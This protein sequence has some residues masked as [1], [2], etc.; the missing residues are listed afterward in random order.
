VAAEGF[1]P[2]GYRWAPDGTLLAVARVDNGPVN[3]WY[4]ADPAH[5]ERPPRELR[6][7]T[8]GTPNALVSLWILGLD[9]SR[10][11]VRWDRA[12]YE[13]LIAVHW[14]AA[15]L[16][17]TV[18][19]R[20]QSILRVFAADP[21]TG[22]TRLLR[23]ERD[24]AWVTVVP[25]VPVLTA[26]GALVTTMDLDGARRLAVDGTPVTPDGLQVRE[27]LAVDGETV[28]FAASAEP[29]EEHVWAYTGGALER[30]TAEPGWHHGWRAGG[31]T[32]LASECLDRGVEITVHRDGRRVAAI[33]NRM[34]EPLVTPRITLLALGE[35]ELRS[36]VLF[37]T[38]HVP[39]S[40]RLP[41]LLD[42]YGGPAAQ[43]VRVARDGYLASQW[44]ADQGFAVLVTDGRGTPG[45][46]PEWERS[47]HLDIADP[48]LRDQIDALHAA[49]E[50]YPDD[51]DL[52]R[53]GIR[54]WSFG[55]FLAAFAV[56]RRPDVFHAAVA[57]A[58]PVDHA[59]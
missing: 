6:Y 38:G 31:T 32:V 44:F 22:E 29:A 18:Q 53:V 33:G 13:Y 47:I 20:A 11:E 4:L 10:V 54:G 15:G 43:R 25:G 24:P 28:L 37:P 50:R 45:R 14:S 23:E 35:R 2:G 12:A 7:P 55:G 42:P 49:A 5:P 1:R 36:A 9:G 56:L 34:E 41:V 26:S 40:R 51:L 48:V 39:G 46:S 57:G 27:V 59:L 17:V 3:R 30:L 21:D 16:L 19:N 52:G 8:T 58:P